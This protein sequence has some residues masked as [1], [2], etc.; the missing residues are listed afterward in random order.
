MDIYRFCEPRHPT[1]IVQY[2]SKFYEDFN[3]AKLQ[4]PPVAAT[5]SHQSSPSTSA[6]DQ[7][8]QRWRPPVRNGYKLNVDAATNIEQKK[9]G[10]GAIL[11]DQH[12]TVLAALSK[13]VQGSFK[14]DEMEAKALFHA[15]NWV[16]Q[17]QFPLTHIET[18][19]SRVSNA[20]NR[21]N[22]DL[23]CFSDLIMDIRCLLS[24]FPQVLVTHVKRTAN[25]AAHGLAKYALGLDEDFVWIGEIPY[26]VFSDVVND[27]NL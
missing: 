17:S 4:I 12:G 23:S 2:A 19:A 21:L 13:A 3:K 24:S 5:S 27:S 15:V 14:S 20:L 6:T 10:I 22:F 25:Q 1:A 8:V 7:H 11:R 18:D 9:L 26:P 16:S